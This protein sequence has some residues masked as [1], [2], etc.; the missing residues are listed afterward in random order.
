MSN[1]EYDL[2]FLDTASQQLKN[3][4]LSDVLY[5]PIG[6]KQPPDHSPYPKLTI[7]GVLLSQSRAAVTCQTE[8][9]R[10]KLAITARD[11]E[12]VRKSWAVFWDKKGQREF[13]AR[14]SL[15]RNFLEDYQK[16]PAGHFDRYSYESRHRVQLELLQRDISIDN[17]SLELLPVLDLRLKSLFQKGI[18]IWDQN[19]M[20]AFPPEPYWF[21]Y[22]RLPEFIENAESK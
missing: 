7:G 13:K 1:A 10:S 15:W 4:L 5:W 18:F 14:T 16:N 22:G 6:L 20:A 2:K 9:E 19:L 8:A 12:D 21:L 17:G 3:Y 11:I